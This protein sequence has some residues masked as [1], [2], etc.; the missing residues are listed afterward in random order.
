MSAER[1]NKWFFLD[2]PANFWEVEALLRQF[3]PVGSE[4]NRDALFYEA[5][6]AA[7]LA[8]AP[9]K[10]H[11]V[12]PTSTSVLAASVLVMAIFLAKGFLVKGPEVEESAVKGSAVES[13]ATVV[14]EVVASPVVKENVLLP[15][16]REL[17]PV[18]SRWSHRSPFLTM[19]DRTLRMEFDEP[20]SFAGFD[21]LDDDEAPKTVTARELMQELLGETS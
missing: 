4:I 13:L 19:R 14:A 12:W 20:A 17:E 8:Q 5:G 6:W 21:D 3:S 7:A 18:V 11:W 10:T 15:V 9:V 16:V 1:G 2:F